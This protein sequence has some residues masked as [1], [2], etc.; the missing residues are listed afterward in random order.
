MDVTWDEEI[1]PQQSIQGL[2]ND[3]QEILLD[4]EQVSLD[5]TV[6]NVLSV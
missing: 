6:D 1:I 2:L 4:L 5:M 3:F